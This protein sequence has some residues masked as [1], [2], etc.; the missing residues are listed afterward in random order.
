MVE[1][2]FDS[3]CTWINTL[4]DSEL[5]ILT[6]KCKTLIADRERIKRNELRQ[7]LMENLQNALS[8]ILHNG[9]TL[10]I[11]NTERDCHDDYGC[12]V[13]NPDEIYSITMEQRQRYFIFILIRLYVHSILHKINLTS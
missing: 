6:S 11:E 9:F 5:E 8:D 13:F 3:I 1:N 10:T 4:S 7:E 12:V 2:F